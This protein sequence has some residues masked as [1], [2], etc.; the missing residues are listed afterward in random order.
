MEKVICFISIMFIFGLTI[1]PYDF[2]QEAKETD[3]ELREEIKKLAPS[4][5]EDGQGRLLAK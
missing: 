2:S 3:Y 1:T 5:L 4:S